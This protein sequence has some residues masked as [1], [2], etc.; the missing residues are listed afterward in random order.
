VIIAAPI[1][2]KVPMSLI[3]VTE[4][5]AVCGPTTTPATTYPASSGS[6]RSL[7]RIPPANPAKTINT[8]SAAI[9]N[10]DYR[11]STR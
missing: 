5:P 11:Y 2:A 10:F 4:G 1:S 9:P 6:R 3:C 8:K 7:A